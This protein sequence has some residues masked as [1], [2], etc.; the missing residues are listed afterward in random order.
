MQYGTPAERNNA[1]CELLV[2]VPCSWPSSICGSK[3]PRNSSPS[4][5][6]R[7]PYPCSQRTSY[8]KTSCCTHPDD[9]CKTHNASL[10]SSLVSLSLSE[11]SHD[12]HRINHARTGSVCT[13]SHPELSVMRCSNALARLFFTE[14]FPIS[15][16]H[17]RSALR[18]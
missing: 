4:A 16:P 18:W 1:Y 10:L 14:S 11:T 5:V 17:Q 12:T 2:A 7:A 9:K 13:L 8:T 6:Q 3:N 15:S